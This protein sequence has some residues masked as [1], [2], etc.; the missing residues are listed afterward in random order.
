MMDLLTGLPIFYEVLCNFCHQCSKAPEKM[1]LPMLDGWPSIGSSVVR[2]MMA[3]PT[4]WSNNMQSSFGRDQCKNMVSDGDSKAFSHIVEKEVYGKDIILSKEDCV[5]HV[6]KR[7]GT[8]LRNLKDQCTWK[9]VGKKLFPI[10]QRLTEDRLLQ[11]CMRNA[12]QN[13]NESL[14]NL[15]R[16]YCSKIRFAG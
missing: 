6:S 13:P 10:F 3:L 1:T 12:T 4:Q 9:E 16:Q 11:R 7:M 5:N 2:I 14:H 15:I 8:A